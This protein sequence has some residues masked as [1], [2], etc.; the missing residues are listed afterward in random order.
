[1][2]TMEAGKRA[3]VPE[4]GRR[5]D[6]SSEARRNELDED[7]NVALFRPGLPFNNTHTPRHPFSRP[8]PYRSHPNSHSRPTPSLGYSL[9]PRPST[10]IV[11]G[12]GSSTTTQEDLGDS[13]PTPVF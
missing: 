13:T 6:E 12:T 11:T 5:A 10:V 1:M 2:P 8:V 4:Q 3:S 7:E 9:S